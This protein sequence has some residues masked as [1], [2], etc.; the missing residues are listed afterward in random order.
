MQEQLIRHYLDLEPHEDKVMKYAAAAHA[1]FQTP[2]IAF[3]SAS[4]LMVLS[5]AVS[6]NGS[7][8]SLMWPSR[9]WP[10]LQC[11]NWSCTFSWSQSEGFCNF[12]V[13]DWPIRGL[14]CYDRR[15]FWS[16][17]F[18]ISPIWFLSHTY[19]SSPA[20][21]FFCN[22]GCLRWVL[23]NTGNWKIV[24][25]ITSCHLVLIGFK[26][27]CQGQNLLHFR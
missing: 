21:T 1:D 9:R 15:M 23:V 25:A 3:H 18:P 4:H 20:T 14:I 12:T 7:S 17:V 26:W 22:F 6:L 5:W 16:F 13:K 10:S 8:P 11:G 19:K 24:Q 2:I 27:W